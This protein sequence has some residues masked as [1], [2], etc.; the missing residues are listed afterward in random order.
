MDFFAGI[1]F[2]LGG[3]YPEYR[4]TN[5]HIPIYYGI[6][7]NHAG[8]VRLCIN[9]QEEYH[10][11]GPYAFISHPGAFFEYG[12]INRQPRQHHYICF[13]GQRVEQYINS[14]LLRLNSDKPLIKINHPDKFRQTMVEL[15]KAIN[16]D[17]F[18][19]DRMVLML[20]DLLLQLHEQDDHDKKLPAWQTPHFTRLLEQIGKNPQANWNFDQEAKM[21]NVTPVH[22]RRL[23][24]QFCG[25]PPQQ[26]LLQRRLRMA[27]NLL[28]SSL[29]PIWDI[30]VQ[31]GIDDIFYFSRVF[32]KT[33][34][35]SPLAYRKEFVGK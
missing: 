8:P 11:E 34:A 22:Y 35:V 26:Y 13:R 30:A 23:F 9:H 21:I 16:S 3:H 25:L 5:S 15:T 7:Y 4:I 32:K 20:E 28:I 2:C 12:S 14:D 29:A 6:Q 1:D 18:R 17:R 31:V 24:K 33:Y 10:A 19:H 27:A